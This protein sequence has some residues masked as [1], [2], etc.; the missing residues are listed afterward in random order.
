M[1]EL[2]LV[3]L[4]DLLLVKRVSAKE[5]AKRVTE[6]IWHLHKQQR[7]LFPGMF[8]EP[9]STQVIRKAAASEMIQAILANIHYLAT[10]NAMMRTDAFGGLSPYAEGE[11]V[12]LPA[13]FSPD[14]PARTALKLVAVL[15]GAVPD[16]AQ[17]LRRDE[18]SGNKL[19]A[20]L[21]DLEIPE[22]V[23]N[24]VLRSD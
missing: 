24:A 2:E 7:E 19:Q 15:K 14:S 6:E 8:Q 13:Q 20:A 10:I 16:L 12:E 4:V 11:D 22:A 1:N 17:M 3:R 9:V 23:F 5:Y 21:A 18:K